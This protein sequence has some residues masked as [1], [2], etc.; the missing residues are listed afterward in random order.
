[1]GLP[2]I[3]ASSCTHGTRLST[4]A[5][6]SSTNFSI[7]TLAALFAATNEHANSIKEKISAAVKDAGSSLGVALTHALERHIAAAQWDSSEVYSGSARRLEP[8]VFDANV[9]EYSID[10]DISVW[11]VKDEPT[12]WIVELTVRVKANVGV[13]VEFFVW[14]SID[15]EELSLGTQEFTTE[16]EVEVDVYLTCGEVHLETDPSDWDTDIE[17][18]DGSYALEG[19]EV[20]LDYGPPDDE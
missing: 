3:Q 10:G 19:F 17:I 1:L 9:A 8:E 20:E 14:D 6:D 15:K 12:T 18:A 7:R 13:S 16:E 5:Y 2:R 11:S 4:S